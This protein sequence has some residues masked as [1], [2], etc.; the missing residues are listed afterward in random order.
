MHRPHRKPSSA[1]KQGRRVYKT[2]QLQDA[3]AK[4]SEV[5][6]KVFSDG[7]QIVTRRNKQAV[8]IMK[9]EAYEQLRWKAAKN[10]PS[11]IEA[12]LAM[13]RVRGFK[14]PDRDPNDRVPNDDPPLFG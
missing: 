4:F 7:P 11:L 1:V 12:L 6:D 8:V 10:A 14:I 9:E 2:W 5:F 3:K 13:P